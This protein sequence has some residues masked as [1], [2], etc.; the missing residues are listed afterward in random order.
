MKHI[1]LILLLFVSLSCSGTAIPVYTTSDL[2]KQPITFEQ[3]R[4]YEIVTVVTKDWNPL[5]RTEFIYE[6]YL[7]SQLS[8]DGQHLIITHHR[9]NHIKKKIPKKS[10]QEINVYR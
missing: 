2:T 7:G 5:S 6:H 3:D 8:W 10:I 1:V 9:S 4:E